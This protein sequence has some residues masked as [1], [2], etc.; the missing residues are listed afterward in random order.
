MKY[1]FRYYNFN[2]TTT[3]P[4]DQYVNLSYS[5]NPQKLELA[6]NPKSITVTVEMCD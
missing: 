6:K 3:S 2:I 1:V 5:P 4:W